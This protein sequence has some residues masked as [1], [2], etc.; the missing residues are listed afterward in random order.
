MSHSRR[1]RSPRRPA[2]VGKAEALAAPSRL[3]EA[4]PE[5]RLAGVLCTAALEDKTGLEH[6]RPP[7][8]SSRSANVSIQWSILWFRHKRREPAGPGRA[9][10]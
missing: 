3:W 6:T 1:A 10:F 4:G 8:H 7:A 2:G 5:E 9:P